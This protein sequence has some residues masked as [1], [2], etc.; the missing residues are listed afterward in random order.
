MI[1]KNKREKEKL[2]VRT[3]RTMPGAVTGVTSR[4]FE[5][6]RHEAEAEFG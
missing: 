5:R 2:D 4:I 6:K 3:V 1:S